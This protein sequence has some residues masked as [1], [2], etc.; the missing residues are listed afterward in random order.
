MPLVIAQVHHVVSKTFQ[1]QAYAVRGAREKKSR[2]EK[3]LKYRKQ[4]VEIFGRLTPFFYWNRGVMQNYLAGIQAELAE[5]A[6]DLESKT[7]LLETAVINIE[8]CLRLCNTVMPSFERKGETALF[9]A[10]RRY[11]DTYASLLLRLHDLTRDPGYL[12]K[13]VE[14]LRDAIESASKVDLI[15]LVAESY[16]KIAKVQDELGEHQ[17]ATA[18]FEQASESYRK[19]AEKILVLKDFYRD[20]ATYMKAWSEIERAWLHHAKRE[21]DQAKIHYAKAASLHDSTNRWKY[22]SPNYMAWA[23]LEEAEDLSRREQISEALNS[24]QKAAKFF[25]ETKTILL[26]AMQRI[27][28]ADE[29]DLTQRLIKASTIREEYCRGRI[30]LEDAKILGRKGNHDASSEKY[31]VATDSFKRLLKSVEAEKSFSKATIMKDRQELMPIIILCQAWQ[32]MARAEAEATPSLYLDASKLFE[33]AKESSIDEKT[34]L[35]ALGHSFF[36]KALDAGARFEETRD[37]QFHLSATQHLENAANFYVRAN[38]KTAAEYTTATQRLFDA[39]VYIS[40]ANK[41]TDPAKK[42]R[43]YMAA[44]K[45]L[46]ISMGAFLKSKHPAKSEQVHQILNNVRKERELA[47][48]LTKIL[49]APTI[50]SS[51]TSFAIPSPSEEAAVGLERFEHANIQANLNLPQREVQL[52]EEIEALIQIANIGKQSILL[53]KIEGATP[54]G[55][56]LVEKPEYSSPENRHL[57]MKGKKLDPLK[58]EEVKLVL[59]AMRRGTREFA[60]KITYVD[61]AGNQLTSRLEPISV[62]TAQTTF[63]DRIPTG[64][65]PVDDLLLGGIP[66][67]YAVALTSPATDE[68]EL[69][70]RRFLETGIITGQITF[71]V[72]TGAFDTEVVTPKTQMNFYHFICN[73]SADVITVNRPNIFRLRGIENLLDISIAMNT[74]LRKLNPAD[75]NPRRCC[76]QIVSDVLLQH[77]AIQ[78][79]RWLTRILTELRAKGFT[80]LIVMDLGMH[81]SQETRAVL[82]LFEGEINIY[83]KPRAKSKGRYLAIRRMTGKEYLEA[84]VSLP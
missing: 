63:I 21:Y 16:W 46:Q 81:S 67:G 31:G 38:F 50:T 12:K 7:K 26:E 42:A 37:I 23:R 82:D 19:A 56:Q 60:P 65:E 44:E 14:A 83:D 5:L 35:L 29:K 10:L 17:K 52:G 47:I 79:R 3:A 71:L 48:S 51:T 39:Y 73:P 55:F 80:T 77:K 20:Y 34:R 75:K 24:F 41:E 15:S 76:I 11:Q 32:M 28:D 78:T 40:N 45:V 4:T 69:L 72:S 1:A 13:A 30:A 2:L 53:A 43:F 84:E 36:S 49:V 22:L 9:A 54:G 70:V 59:R 64:Y 68:R 8:E 6:P 25:A 66:E 58:T 62:T 33:E 27:E 74:A 57:N 61:N 18:S